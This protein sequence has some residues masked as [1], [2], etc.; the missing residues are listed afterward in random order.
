MA[1]LALLADGQ[2]SESGGARISIL[3]RDDTWPSDC[4]LLPTD[5][6][7]KENAFPKDSRIVFEEASHTYTVDGKVAPT[8]VTSFV[9][10]PFYEFDAKPKIERMSHKRRMSPEYADLSDREVAQLWAAN[11]DRASKLGT[12]MHAA[13][14]VALNTG[15]WSQDPTIVREMELAKQFFEVEVDARG[16]K[17]YRT[18]P[19]V[20]IDPKENKDA[21]LLP[22]SVDCIFRD[23]ESGRFGIMD[24]KRCKEVPKSASGN[25]G[26]GRPPFDHLESVKYNKYSLQLC[27]Y[28]YILRTHYDLDVDLNLLY[29][30]IIHPENKSGGYEMIQAD[31][32]LY[33][34]IAK[35]MVPNFAKYC[36]YAMENQK[37]K[38]RNEA[39]RSGGE[40]IVAE[41]EE[42]SGD[43]KCGSMI[44]I[45]RE[46]PAA[47]AS[48]GKAVVGA[49]FKLFRIN[50]DMKMLTRSWTKWHETKLDPVGPFMGINK[51]HILRRIK[52][53]SSD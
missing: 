7:A 46:N 6:L 28:A 22:G 5:R 37:V 1:G 11:A 15:Y 32:K 24:W 25:F 19:T 49:G 8:S 36:G 12:R 16:W 20:F 52:E 13:I 10:S 44:Y 9:S 47:P 45:I 39:W 23:T 38:K 53:M 43:I 18:E 34:L 41:E 14:E 27:M 3:E 31:P 33:E 2:A 48:V 21:I 51:D 26:F 42:V 30:V 35:E 4:R 17:V 40:Y 50:G 29:I